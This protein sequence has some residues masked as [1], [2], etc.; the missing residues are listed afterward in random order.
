MKRNLWKG[1]SLAA[2]LAIASPS[3]AQEVGGGGASGASGADAGS[4]GG[5]GV[6]GPVQQ[7]TG[8]PPNGVHFFGTLEEG[9]E[10]GS[11]GGGLSG[12]AP[13]GSTGVFGITGPAQVYGVQVSLGGEMP[14]YPHGIPAT[15]DQA[16]QRALANNADM[17]LAEANLRQAQAAYEQAK[18][19]LT[20]QVMI[21]MEQAEIDRIAYDRLRQANEAAANSVPQGELHLSRFAVRKS[22]LELQYLLGD[23]PVSGTASV[24]SM[25]M[26]MGGSGGPVGLSG[27]GGQMQGGGLMGMSANLTHVPATATGG[28]AGGGDASMGGGEESGGSDGQPDASNRRKWY[29]DTLSQ[30]SGP[31]DLHAGSAEGLA[32][33]LTKRMQVPVI[34]DSR[35]LIE[36]SEED[37]HVA[38]ILNRASL[39]W[40]DILTAIADTHDIA[41]VIR[42]YGVLIT[43]PE[44][45]NSVNVGSGFGGG[46]GGMGSGGGGGA[47]GGRQGGGGGFF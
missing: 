2:L 7:G 43:T 42:D 13:I 1:A 19:K 46:G 34:V 25:G 45:A 30:P 22:Q 26:D 8:A 14:L 44:K 5:G 47:I 11:V 23:L 4:S 35:A 24:G 3:L 40:R 6:S 33:E 32:Q 10:G 15:L 18:L 36:R 17:R 37:I 20:H 39:T 12:D 29:E 21:A 9:G 41:F 38:L 31:I 16:I 28:P 27:F